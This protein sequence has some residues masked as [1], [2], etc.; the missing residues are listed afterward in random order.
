MTLSVAAAAVRSTATVPAAHPY[1]AEPAPRREP[2]FDDEVPERHLSLVGPL[3]QPLPLDDPGLDDP[4]AEPV[5][6]APADPFADR[7]TG[8]EELPE[9][10]LMAR[11]LVIGVVEIAT[12]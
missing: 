3:D 5:L 9:P 8:D 6:A 10:A 4:G 11:R 7:P 12:G 1:Q 2:P